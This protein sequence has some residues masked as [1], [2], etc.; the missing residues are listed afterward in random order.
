MYVCLGQKNHQ[1]TLERQRLQIYTEETEREQKRERE[2]TRQRARTKD[3]ARERERAR[4]F[5]IEIGYQFFSLSSF[6]SSICQCCLDLF[7]EVRMPTFLLQCLKYIATKLLYTFLTGF[8]D[9]PDEAKN[10]PTKFK[11]LN[12]NYMTFYI[13]LMASVA[14]R[15]KKTKEEATFALRND[16]WMCRTFQWPHKTNT[17]FYTFYVS[18]HMQQMC[19]DACVCW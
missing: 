2:E 7:A 17:L 12:I 6:S 8:Y 13:Q 16:M 14:I 11:L 9:K 4:C 15:Q 18:S 19:Y 1:A 3:R 10:C 5:P